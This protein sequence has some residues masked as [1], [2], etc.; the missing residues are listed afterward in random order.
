MSLIY[1]GLR[2]M[3]SLSSTQSKESNPAIY[4]QSHADGRD[5]IHLPFD[6][7]PDGVGLLGELSP[8]GLVV[9]LLAQ[10]GGEGRVALWHQLPHVSPLAVQL[11]RG[12][13]RWI[14]E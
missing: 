2:Y 3:K 6:P 9:L 5:S 8:E 11:L 14:D 4:L 1:V 7:G 10:L 13:G 12:S